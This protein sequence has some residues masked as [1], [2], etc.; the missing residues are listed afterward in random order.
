MTNINK[1]HVHNSNG[2][3]LTSR[4]SRTALYKAWTENK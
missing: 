2:K 1:D 3:L 4:F